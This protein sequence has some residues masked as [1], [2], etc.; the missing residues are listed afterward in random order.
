MH[1]HW[2][3]ILFE[4]VLVNRRRNPQPKHTHSRLNTWIFPCSTTT[5]SDDGRP[6]NPHSGYDRES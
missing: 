2:I 5:I 1:S 4:F 3:V 6:L